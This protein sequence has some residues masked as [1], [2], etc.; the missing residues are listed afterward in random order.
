MKGVK[1][2]ALKLLSFHDVES[3]SISSVKEVLQCYLGLGSRSWALMLA[4]KAVSVR[5]DKPPFPCRYPC[6]RHHLAVLYLD[7]E[8]IVLQ[9]LGLNV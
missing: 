9:A 3:L 4:K 7:N 6:E 2:W 5:G 1:S 8:A